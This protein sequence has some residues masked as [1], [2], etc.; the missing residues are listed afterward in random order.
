MN[1]VEKMETKE[2]W[3]DKGN[4]NKYKTTTS[5]EHNKVTSFRHETEEQWK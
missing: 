1:K 4:E 2:K 3:R 5:L